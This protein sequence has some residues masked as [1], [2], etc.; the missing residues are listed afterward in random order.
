MT[1]RTPQL[2]PAVVSSLETFSRAAS[3][4]V[5]S[6][7]CLV[8]LGWVLDVG[9]PWTVVMKANAAV[10]FVL[11]GVSLRLAQSEEPTGRAHLAARGCALAAGPDGAGRGGQLPPRR[12]RALPAARRMASG[13]KSGPGAHPH[14][15]PALRAGA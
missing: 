11:A 1:P 13:A 12:H 14:R 7:G 10:A 9:A 15:G 4:L 8:L 2:N 6:I 5:V 3:S